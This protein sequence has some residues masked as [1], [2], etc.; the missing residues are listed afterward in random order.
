MQIN[1]E[2]RSSDI[3]QYCSDPV[4]HIQPHYN[5]DLKVNPGIGFALIE[6]NN[7]QQLGIATTL[8]LVVIVD[9]VE[10]ED[11]K[12]VSFFNHLYYRYHRDRGL[13][14]LPVDRAGDVNMWYDSFTQELNIRDPLTGKVR[15]VSTYE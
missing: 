1:L 15:K 11:G 7:A 6:P 4:L 8:G 12:A 9:G 2:N 3:I 5:I 10:L 13:S 14:Y